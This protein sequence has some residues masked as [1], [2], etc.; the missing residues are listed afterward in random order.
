MSSGHTRGGKILFGEGQDSIFLFSSK[1]HWRGKHMHSHLA[2]LG[3]PKVLKSTQGHCSRCDHIP[4]YPCFWIHEDKAISDHRRW[5]G[6]EACSTHSCLPSLYTDVIH[7]AQ[8]CYSCFREEDRWLVK[9]PQW[10]AHCCPVVPKP[11][12]WCEHPEPVIDALPSLGE[13]IVMPG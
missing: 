11:W 2:P 8:P 5:A 9:F 1:G 12:G 13:C 3:Q 7:G 4:L 10:T 6:C